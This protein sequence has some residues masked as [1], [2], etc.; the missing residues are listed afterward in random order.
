[1]A[2]ASPTEYLPADAGS[3]KHGDALSRFSAVRFDECRRKHC[4]LPQAARAANRRK[5]DPT[6]RSRS[7]RN[8]WLGGAQQKMPSDL[9]G[10]MR[11]RAAS[12]A[13]DRISPT[14]SI[15]R[16]TNDRSR[17]DHCHADQ[18]THQRNPA[19]TPGNQHCRH[20]RYPLG[21]GSRRQNR[22]PQRWQNSGQIA[23]KEEFLKIKDP[24]L[25][26]FFENAILTQGNTW[27]NV[28]EN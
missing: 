24:L 17:P 18:R 11:K 20:S 15:V 6:A 14:C 8:G 2:S 9:S 10:G 21:H 12:G 27:R 25:Q 16:R 1:M 5:R 13:T 3:Q 23:P 22:L 7:S 26:A 19:E 4:I 28:K